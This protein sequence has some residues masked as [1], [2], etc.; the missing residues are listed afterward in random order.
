[1]FGVMASGVMSKVTPPYGW[2][3]TPEGS[4]KVAVFHSKMKRRDFGI[5]DCSGTASALLATFD[6]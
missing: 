4:E 5:I 3:R 1:M 6:S 2:N